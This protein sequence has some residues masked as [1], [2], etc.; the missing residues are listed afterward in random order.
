MKFIDNPRSGG[1]EVLRIAEGPKPVPRAGEVVIRVEAAGVNR[2]DI[3]QREGK[4]PPPP[5]ASPILGLEVAGVIASSTPESKWKVGDRVCALAPGGG[6]AEYCAVPEPQC[7]PI[8]AGLSFEEA[9][10]LPETFFT[11]WANVFQIGRLAAGE[12]LLV[13][14]GTS[15][16]GTT[17]IQLARALGA[18]VYA[19]AGS[20][21]KCAA[22]TELGAAAAINYREQDFAAEIARLTAGQGVDVILDM[23]GAAYTARNLE[24][25]A[26]Q[27]RLVQIAVWQGAEATV[28][29]ARVMQRRL[30]I[31]GFTMRPR[32]VEDKGVI[33]RELLERVW[34]LL[35]SHKVR[36]IVDRVFPLEDAAEA[37]RHLEAGQHVGK[38]ILKL[39]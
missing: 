1:P 37:H 5:G 2:P 6:Y 31:T 28:N 23:V 24:C 20:A 33:A 21:A 13:H 39:N 36:V 4:Y 22:C 29:L 16:I 11:V 7:L 9:A 25:L 12:T 8:P 15:G 10:G 30:T 3:A 26:A 14:G 35:E 18:T 34:P 17:A 38:V 19:T 32:T 27:G